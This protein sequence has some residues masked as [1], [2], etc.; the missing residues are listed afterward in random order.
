MLYRC[1][2]SWFKHCGVQTSQALA[3][4]LT[5]FMLVVPLSKLGL[6]KVKS[7]TVRLGFELHLEKQLQYL[8]YIL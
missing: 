8:G 2:V 5:L 1:R 6:A 7:Q 3:L 4:A